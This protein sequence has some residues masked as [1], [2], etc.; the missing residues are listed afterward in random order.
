MPCLTVTIML[1]VDNVKAQCPL[2]TL[3]Q[4]VECT[5]DCESVKNM[6]LAEWSLKT[7]TYLTES[8]FITGK[9]TC[10]MFF[11]RATT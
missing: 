11:R 7:Y 1:K 3:C 8:L 4:F 6:V 9:P 10:N 2:P 5:A